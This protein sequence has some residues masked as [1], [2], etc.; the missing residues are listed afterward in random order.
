VSGIGPLLGEMTAA[1]ER[2]QRDEIVFLG[3]ANDQ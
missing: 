3:K 1:E 2:L